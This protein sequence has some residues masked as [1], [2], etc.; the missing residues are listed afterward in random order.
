ME[1]QPAQ[2]KGVVDFQKDELG[3]GGV[4]SGEVRREAV[5][6]KPAKAGST[7]GSSYRLQAEAS[8]SKA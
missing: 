3:N 8:E 7:N 5:L 2:F 6:A 4:V 1:N